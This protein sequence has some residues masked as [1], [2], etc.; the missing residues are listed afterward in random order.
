MHLHE[1]ETIGSVLHAV[2]ARYPERTA[3]ID[4]NRRLSYAEL[5]RLVDQTAATMLSLG[6]QKA[7]HVGIW[8]KDDADTLTVLYAL[9]RI[10]AVPVPLCTS[11]LRTELETCCLAA[12]VSCLFVGT[13][14]KGQDFAQDIGP[15][16]IPVTVYPIDA[17]TGCVSG[18]A[19]AVA[20]AEALVVPSDP[21]TILFTSGTT[22]HAKPVL[23]THYARV[24]TM[25]AQAEIFRAV[26]ED[27][28]CSVLPMYHC[29]SLTATVLAAMSAGACVCFPADRRSQTI[30][31]TIEQ[32]RCSVLTAVPT[33]F[34]ALLRRLET[35]D[36]DLR[37]LKKGMIGGSTYSEEFFLQISHALGFTLLSSLGQTEATAGL[38]G[39]T[40]EDSLSV[41]ARTIGRFFPLVEGSIRDPRTNQPLGPG[42]E[43]EICVRGYN[44]MEG[45]YK[46]PEATA[47]VIDADGWLHTGDLGSLDENGYVRYTGRLKELIIRG[48]ENIAPSELEDIL[49]TDPRILQAKVIGIPDPHY[50]EEICACIVKE[51]NLT[52]DDVR[53]M[54]AARAADFKVPKYVLFMD[55]LP[56]TAVGKVDLH[57][58]RKQA[59]EALGC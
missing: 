2:A 3:V 16:Q 19:D 11:F 43:G 47:K 5:D 25:Y 1:N 17:A 59:A 4:A 29:F 6:I 22:G 46:L 48:G 45:Y 38:T 20:V 35:L 34:S 21:D 27:V 51:G 33:L 50:T 23:T 44:V 14:H 9:W 56:M 13:G 55:T 26:P 18:S 40:M 36:V 10:G 15:L 49:S 57:A 37:S 8:A 31:Q 54:I 7:S 41:R 30:L 39:C 42:K 28:F 53:Q 24:N 32:E 12:D 58:L 52:E